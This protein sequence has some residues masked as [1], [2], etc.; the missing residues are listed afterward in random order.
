MIVVKPLKRNPDLAAKIELVAVA[1]SDGARA[2]A[3]AKEWGIPQSYGSYAEMLADPNV[4]AVYNSLPNMLH[5]EWTVRALQAGKHV[6]CGKPISSNARE[7]VVMQRAAEDAGKVCLEAFHAIRHPMTKRVRE[8]VVEGKVGTIK[9]V[10]VKYLVNLEGYDG[11]VRSKMHTPTSVKDDYRMR[12]ESSGG[13]TMDLGCYCVAIIRSVTGEEPQI[14]KAVAQPWKE[15]KD[16]DASMQCEMALPSGAVANFECSFVAQEYS[17][18]IQL[19]ICGTAGELR[20]R[21]L[22]NSHKTNEIELESWDDAGIISKESVDDPSAANTND[23]FY[24]QLMAFVD[25]IRIQEHRACPGLPWSYRINSGN[26][27]SDF[28]RNMAVIDEIYRTAGMVPRST[29]SSPPAPYDRI[30]DR[31]LSKL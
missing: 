9:S 8:L 29:K 4:D 23:S 26:T 16:I 24:Y 30:G 27:P 13:V 10:S 11:R 14:L 28:V 17:Q 1:A 15:D 12:S 20:A 21:G 18:P 25:E 3:F 7:A 31:V 2:A 19:T 22:F 5:C 6:L